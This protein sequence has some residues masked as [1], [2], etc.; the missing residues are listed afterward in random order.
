VEDAAIMGQKTR[1]TFMKDCSTSAAAM[2]ALSGEGAGGGEAVREGTPYLCITCGS[3]FSES[4][5]PPLHCPICE[6][7]RQ[8]VNPDGQKWTTLEELRSSHKNTI[9]QEEPDLY[10]INTEPKFGIGQRAFLIRT[11]KGNVLWDCVA[12]VDDATISRINELGGIAEIAISHPHYYTA[13]VE[14]SRAFGGAPI[15][16]H[17]AERPW[18]MR[19]DPSIHFWKGQVQELR[20]GLKLV[21]TGGHFAGYQVLHWP[22]GAGGRGAL[23]AGDQPQ[24]CMDPKQVSFMYS[25]PNY[26]PLNGAQI[27]HIVECLD[28]LAYDRV[29][30]AFFV[31][32]KGIIPTKGKEVVQRSADRYLRAIG[33]NGIRS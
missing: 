18:V 5:K 9:K 25:Y 17:E 7:E 21:S 8:Y 29:Y 30:G 15:H 12:L 2:V 16:L 20:A 26:I 23:M 19:P 22:K 27:A 11:D 28:P 13:M 1:R 3:Q 4:A 10:S 33:G 6:D 14:W 24:I 32:G 31:R